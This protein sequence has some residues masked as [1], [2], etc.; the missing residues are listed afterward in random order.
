MSRKLRPNLPGLAFHVTN[1]TN[2]KVHWFTEDIRCEVVKIIAETLPRSDARLIA[3]TVMSNHFHLL[4]QQ[5]N[6]PLSR[7]MQP[8]CRRIAIVVKRIHGHAG[9]VFGQPY[10]SIPC[11]T[12]DHVRQVIY[13]THRN[14]VK[15]S[16]CSDAADYAWSSHHAYTGTQAICKAKYELPALMLWPALE[17]FACTAAATAADMYA[18]YHRFCTWREE[19]DALPEGV[20]RAPGPVY[21]WGDVWWTRRFRPGPPPDEDWVPD[22]RDLVLHA[23]RELAPDMSLELLRLPRRTRERI[24][25]CKQIIARAVSAGY[26]G[27]EIA[28]FLNV[29]ECTVSR[30]ADKVFRQQVAAQTTR[31]T[32]PR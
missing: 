16:I 31:P 25:L 3:Q 15:A 7:L 18:G 23:L 4:V 8:I 24:N 1:R 29:A 17:L 32:P 2:G 20:P 5:G 6:A 12:A 27:V 30:I 21:P 19:C 13:Y 26:T 28:R 14:P 9:H 22:L 11:V 10:A